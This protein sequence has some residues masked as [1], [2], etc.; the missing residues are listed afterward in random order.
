MISKNK[1]HL[2]SMSTGRL[3]SVLCLNRTDS[4]VWAVCF[5]RDRSESAA[6]SG[7]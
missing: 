4:N 3:V 6:C 2:I 1:K 7:Y 5:G